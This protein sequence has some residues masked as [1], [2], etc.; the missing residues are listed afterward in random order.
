MSYKIILLSLVSFLAVACDGGFERFAPPAN[1]ITGRGAKQ[2]PKILSTTPADG[3]TV[4]PVTGSTGTQIKVIF[5]MTM[6]P[7]T[8][9]VI[10]T[11]VQD[12]IGNAVGWYNVANS[13]ATFTWSST[14]YAN[15]TLTIQLG[16]VRWPENNV[17]GFDFDNSTLVN[18]DDMPLDNSKKFSFTVGWDP[19]KYKVVQTGQYQCYRYEVGTGWREE[20]GCLAGSGIIGTQDY[21]AGQNGFV[22]SM[23]ATYVGPLYGANIGLPNLGRRFRDRNPQNMISA[24]CNNNASDPCYPYSVDAVTTLIWKTCSQGQTYQNTGDKCYNSG[25]DYTWGEAVNA[26]AAMNTADNG[27]GYGGRKDWRLPTVQELEGLVDYG[28]RVKEGNPEPAPGYYEAPAIDG[29]QDTNWSQPEG[30]FPNTSVLKGYWTATGVAALFNGVKY[31]GNAYVV[32][33]KKGMV[34]ADSS[35]LLDSRRQTSNRKK[36][37]CV[38]GPAIAAPTQS[39][40]PSVKANGQAPATSAATFVGFDANATF[41]VVSARSN[42]DMVS[43]N[44]QVQLTFNIPANQSTPPAS[45]QAGATTNYCIALATATSCGPSIIAISSTSVSVA[46]DTV[47][48]VTGAQAPNT[49]YKLFVSNVK[50]ATGSLSLTVDRVLFS[51]ATSILSQSPAPVFNVASAVSSNLSSVQVTFDRLPDTT[52]AVNTAFYKIVSATSSPFTFAGA[53]SVAPVTGATLSGY[54]VTL[55]TTLA[56]NTPYAVMVNGVTY[57]GSQVVDDTVNRLRWQRCRKGN[58]DNATC[59]DDGDGSND[60]MYWNDA[61]N[62]CASLNATRYDN[63]TLAS[64]TDPFGWRAPTINELKSIAKRELFGT[65]GYSIDTAIF[66]TPNPLAEGFASSTNYMLNGDPAPGA[67]AGN[68]SINKVWSFNYIAGF[69]GI[70]QKDFSALLPVGL[71]P[72]KINIRCVRNLP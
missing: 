17:I 12:L 39:L 6:N 22:D 11:Y 26:C 69:T 44:Y 63:Y 19:G 41:N 32:E 46:G 18:L 9:P 21:P 55:A 66:P 51:G 43:G 31:Y 20:A 35:G 34:G 25:N 49:A 48:L 40:T 7:N 64:S 33:F 14:S 10:N 71:K 52:Q 23:N 38:A 16:W 54:T 60:A 56:I 27:Q 58:Y 65:L 42:Y 50:S 70:A 59:A 57:A 68:P 36:V 24:N 61:L 37:R 72:A 30:P 15:D 3:A 28:A 13:G 47:T 45:D 62:Y 2:N 67:A 29:Y 8:T 4:S 53:A 1:S 5:D